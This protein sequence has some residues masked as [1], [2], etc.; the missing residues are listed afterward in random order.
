MLTTISLW[1]TMDTK[2]IH[3]I[4][5]YRDA[6]VSLQLHHISEY[7][8]DSD[9][10]IYSRA[11]LS[12]FQPNMFSRGQQRPESVTYGWNFIV[13]SLFLFVFKMKNIQFNFNLTTM[14]FIP[15]WFCWYSYIY[16]EEDWKFRSSLIHAEKSISC[17]VYFG[18]VI[19]PF[20]L[21]H[22]HVR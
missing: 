2:S 5:R 10:G 19:P 1:Y 11:E 6:S 8:S 12:K 9:Y 14:Y 20:L 18:I 7:P 16:E 3:I 21:V 15:I 4:I 22:S 13:N 17:A